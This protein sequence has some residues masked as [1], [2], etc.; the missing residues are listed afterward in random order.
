MRQIFMQKRSIRSAVVVA[1][2]VPAP[3]CG[4][5][6]VLIGNQYSLISAGTESMAVGSTKRDMVEK[7]LKDKDIRKSVIDMVVQDGLQKTAD[8][9]KFEF[10][11]WTPLGYS[12][13][14]VA[15]EV[16][17]QI[18]SIRQGQLVA[19]AGEPHAEI[20]RGRKRLSIPV[21]EGV[22]AKEAAFV[23]LGSIAM[24]AVRRAEPQV[25]ETIAVLGL[26]LVGQLVA[27][28]ITASGARVIGCDLHQSR[29][30]L[31]MKLGT[32]AVFP[33]G[34][35]FVDQVRQYTG[36]VGVDRVMIC[37]AG[38]SNVPVQQAV[39]I[40]RDRGR[41]VVVGL[42]G[43]DVPCEEFYMKE[44][45][46]VISR[47]YGPGRYDPQF[48]D[49]GV[50]YP[51]SYV[52]WTEERNMAEFL[53]MIAANKVQVEPLVSHEY[54]VDQAADAYAMIMDNPNQTLA[55]M[56]KYDEPGSTIER[57]IPA[58]TQ[59]GQGTD[60]AKQVA[61]IGCGNF[62]Q[63]FHLPNIKASPRLHFKRLVTS[64]G[65]SS[66]EMGLRYG[67]AEAGTDPGELWSDPDI[68]AVFVFTRDRSHAGMTADAL[69]AG[70]HVFCEK[71]LACSEEECVA[72]ER[73]AEN[74]DRLCFTGF[75]RRFAPMITRVKDTLDQ[76]SGPKMM[77]FRVNAG[78]LPQN[79][80]VYDPRHA[81]GR[82]VGE[83]CHFIDLFRWLVGTNPVSVV[84]TAMG[85]GATA[86][87]LE[88]LSSQFLFADGSVGTLLYTAAGSSYIGKERLEVFCDGTSIV[89]DDYRQLTM[90]GK[91]RLDLRE[92]KVNKGHAA[93]LEHFTD[94]ITGKCESSINIHDGI[95]ATRWALAA[96]ESARG[97][98]INAG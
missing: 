92:R 28:L 76:L 83:A 50:D 91:Q 49:A 21:P 26:G 34:D 2:E 46:L 13:A 41:L 47:S 88:D 35:Q 37:A 14:G 42:V 65:Q 61:V 74:T 79:N 48:E 30:D 89:M 94:A 22:S 24:Q 33:A 97:Q 23:A 77:H 82:I 96:I 58:T 53:R 69:Q 17:D 54:T 27:Q 15:L 39:K 56:L 62:A 20:I 90:R 63:Q 95:A 57:K 45:D 52:R 75:N 18:G 29:M 11:K 9:V 71:P 31:A 72:L 78:P 19:Y 6:N 7:A 85:A 67:A 84:A 4:S 87:T 70:K 44:L 10:N 25:G 60:G 38:K 55:V 51:L 93:E 64:S 5:S 86:E 1:E 68:D 66:K 32:E 40:A 43:L 80:W 59:N 81:A 98:P 73:L 12:G 16:G 36:G 8:R 3:R